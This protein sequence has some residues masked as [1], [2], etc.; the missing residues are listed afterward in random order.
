M[1]RYARRDVWPFVRCPFCGR[2][3]D[4]TSTMTWCVGC[5]TEWTVTP[6]GAV[7]FDTDQRTPRFA[8]AKAIAKAGGIGIADA[9]GGAGG[10]ESR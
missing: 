3:C 1:K 6:R 2:L 9:R 7:V 8:W 5:Y 4:R 10:E